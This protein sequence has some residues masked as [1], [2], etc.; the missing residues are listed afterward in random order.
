MDSVDESL[1]DLYLDSCELIANALDSD[2]HF[3][4]FCL[5]KG[6]LVRNV[7][8]DS[9][10]HYFGQSIESLANYQ[11]SILFVEAHFGKANA[12]IFK[13]A[14]FSGI[15]GLN[16]TMRLIDLHMDDYVKDGEE[17]IY[18]IKSKCLASFGIVY[19]RFK[20]QELA[21]KYLRRAIKAI[22]NNI[23]RE[24]ME[25]KAAL[26]SNI[27]LVYSNM[28]DF[29]Q[30]EFYTLQAIDLKKSLGLK[31]SIGFNYRILAINAIKN[32]SY[33]LAQKYLTI[34]DNKFRSRNNQNGI[35]KNQFWLGKC[36]YEMGDFPK[37]KN[38]FLQLVGPFESDFTKN[39]L[40]DL[41]EELG[42][43]YAALGEL[44]AAS[45][46]LEKGLIIRKERGVIEDRKAFDEFLLYFNS[47]ES[48]FDDHLAFLK[49]EQEKV[50]LALKIEADEEKKG[51]LYI[52]FTV[53]I[54]FLLAIIVLIATAYSRYKKINTDLQ[55]SIQNTETLFKE[56]HHRVKNNFQVISSLLNLQSFNEEETKSKRALNEAKSRI[57]SMSLVHEMLYRK[58]NLSQIN[59]KDYCDELIS[60]ILTSYDSSDK[61]T[62][63]INTTDLS[64]F[65]LDYAVPLG[66]IFNEAITNSIKHAFN[67]NNT[68]HLMVDLQQN[69]GGLVEI[70]IADNGKGFDLNNYETAENNEGLGI[71]LIYI[72]AEQINGA[73][74]IETAGGT[75][76][77]IVFDPLKTAD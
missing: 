22:R 13:D 21:L 3:G 72:L 56:V 67:D 71:E 40:A 17:K 12:F 76:I 35:Y 27:G 10:I 61:V 18:L 28:G 50:Q 65:N 15:A 68:G 77:K 58:G 20:D 55:E 6:R 5:V 30:S 51:W 29:Q 70:T 63:E 19:E 37:A 45:E 14:F 41:Y 32:G 75:R 48:A 4:K 25:F 11:D 66:L 31:S 54:I 38:E 64:D 9:S 16:Q 69:D 1:S 57:Q 33:S 53:V 24:G 46:Y 36:Y 8:L 47:Q 62:Y 44:N 42:K 74:K 59:F 23:S 49:N 52:M 2:Y 26:F 73:A 60:S 34:A 43:T 39:D 7:S